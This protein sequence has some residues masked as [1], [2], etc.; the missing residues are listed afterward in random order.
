M[1]NYEYFIKNNYTKKVILHRIWFSVAQVFNG[2]EKGTP[3]K[4]RDCT[5]SCN[6]GP[7]GLRQS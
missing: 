7:Q 6:P 1:N 4:N 5:R 2:D 3:V